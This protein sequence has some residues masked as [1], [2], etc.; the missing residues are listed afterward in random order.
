MLSLCRGQPE[1]KCRRAK[2]GRDSGGCLS[3]LCAQSRL[4][5]SSLFGHMPSWDLSISANGSCKNSL[6]N[7]V[8]CLTTIMVKKKKK[9]SYVEVEAHC[10]LYLHWIPL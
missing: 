5:Y 8:Q 1:E 4:A 6:G 2:V 10:L 7:L 3:L 9:V